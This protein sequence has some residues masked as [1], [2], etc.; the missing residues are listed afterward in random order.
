MPNER[1]RLRAHRR[2]ARGRRLRGDDRRSKT[3]MSSC[4]T[5]AAS[6]RTP[7]TSSTGCSGHLKVEKE[8]RPD[9]QIAVGG[10]LAQKDRDLVRAA[11]RPRRRRLRHAQRAPGGRVVA[12]GG[13]AR[14][15][16]SRSSTKPSATTPKPSPVRCRRGVNST[17]RR[18]SPSRS[19][20]TTRARSASCRRCAVARSAARSTISSTRSASS[21]LPASSRSRLLGQNVN[22][23]GRDLTKRG[24]LFA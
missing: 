4:S 14:A 24:P 12:P 3:P 11:G 22:S 2:P 18:G 10:C 7:T 21:R 5:R 1:A 15:R 23:Y 19:A 13:R 8:R 6:E 20:A 9:L 16:S 17:T